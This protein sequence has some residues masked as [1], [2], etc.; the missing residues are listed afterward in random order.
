LFGEPRV[1]VRD[2]RGG[3]EDRAVGVGDVTLL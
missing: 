2:R 1:V 3:V